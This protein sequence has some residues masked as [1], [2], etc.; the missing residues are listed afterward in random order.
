MVRRG[1]KMID[2]IFVEKGVK[3][4]GVPSGAREWWEEETRKA[5][6]RRDSNASS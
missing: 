4:I 5:N 1:N 6:D 3:R 2:D